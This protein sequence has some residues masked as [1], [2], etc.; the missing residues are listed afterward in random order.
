M[1]ERIESSKQF[2][3]KKCPTENEASDNRRERSIPVGT[4]PQHA[5][6]EYD[7]KWRSYK[8]EYGLDFFKQ[9]RFRSCEIDCKTDARQQHGDAAPAAEAHLLML[10]YLSF[11]QFFVEINRDDGRS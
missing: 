2:E 5:Q 4:L 8:K 9:R 10:G 11:H 3:L 6:C 7:R 1:I